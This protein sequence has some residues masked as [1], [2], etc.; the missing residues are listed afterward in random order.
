MKRRELA[1]Y[2]EGLALKHLQKKGY[3]LLEQN[4]QKRYGELDL[5]MLDPTG[6]KVVVVEVKTRYLGV[7]VP[8]KEAV[9]DRKISQLKSTTLYYK[10]EKGDSV[11]DSLRID[12]IAIELTSL[13]EIAVFEHIKNIT[14]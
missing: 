14:L 1:R 6:E 10:K 5:V 11:P 12:V 8:P 13:D 4:Y 2:G 9:T 3:K 7:G